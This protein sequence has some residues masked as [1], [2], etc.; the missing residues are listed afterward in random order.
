M[1]G[2]HG[3]QRAQTIRIY[4]R[5]HNDPEGKFTPKP[6]TCET[7]EEKHRKG[8]GASIVFYITYPN[9]KRIPFDGAPRVVEGSEA[10]FGDGAVVGAVYTD[11]VHFATCPF[12]RLNDQAKRAPAADSQKG[13]A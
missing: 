3:G 5:H 6:A 11:N 9:Q 10:V 13:A 4:L 2:P 12:A 7:D 1:P 8:C